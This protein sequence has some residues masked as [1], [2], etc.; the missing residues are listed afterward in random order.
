MV[1]IRPGVLVSTR[2]RSRSGA[3]RRRRRGLSRW[4]GGASSR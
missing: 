2:P 1:V 4:L 3:G